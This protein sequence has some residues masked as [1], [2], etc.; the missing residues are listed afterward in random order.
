MKHT[1]PRFCNL[2]EEKSEGKR[3]VPA[4]RNAFFFRGNAYGCVG[5][6]ESGKT[7][8]MKSVSRS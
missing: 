3:R 4:E 5:S 7:E 8:F 6:S 2:A 1:F